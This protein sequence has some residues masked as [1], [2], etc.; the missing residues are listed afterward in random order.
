MQRT[1]TTLMAEHQDRS[2][3]LRDF[4]VYIAVGTSIAVLAVTLGVYQAKTG[5]KPEVLL[6]WVGFAI[7][8][9]LVFLW[10]IRTYRPFWKNGRFWRLLGLFATIHF[11]LGIGILVR[12]TVASLFPFVVVTPLEYF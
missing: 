6:K 4:L 9:M 12:T 3:R 10:A 7:M 8:T 1:Q 5:D 2:H 11:V